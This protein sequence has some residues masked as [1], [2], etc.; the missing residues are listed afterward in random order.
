MSIAA[1]DAQTI[2]DY[3]VG[4]FEGAWYALASRPGKNLGGGN[5]LFALLA[6]ILLEFACR[7]CAQ[8]PTGAKLLSVGTALRRIDQRYFATLPGECQPSRGFKL[9]GVNPERHLLGWLFD[10]IR[11]GKAHQYQSA[12][13]R[14]T[15]G[16]FDIDLSGAA[17]GRHL[18]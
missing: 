7:R 3:I 12:I 11:N 5:F 18:H 16:D 1:L 14:L 9:P 15:D 2:F 17:T 8:D 6:M 13:A 4:D 10:L